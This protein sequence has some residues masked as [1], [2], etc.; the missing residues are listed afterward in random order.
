IALHQDRRVLKSASDNARF[1]PRA[2]PVIGPLDF[3]RRDITA[4]ME[5]KMPVAASEPRV[6]QIEL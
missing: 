3:L 2:L 6:H 1:A 4:I 5:G